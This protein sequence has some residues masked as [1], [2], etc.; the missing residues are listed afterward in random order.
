F[1]VHLHK[2]KKAVDIPLDGD[3]G[4]PALGLTVYPGSKLAI[5]LGYDF[6]FDFGLSRTEDFYV[7]AKNS[8]LTLSFDAGLGPNFHAAAKLAFLRVDVSDAP[9]DPNDPNNLNNPLHPTSLGNGAFSV[10]LVNPL[11]GDHLTLD[12]IAKGL[13]DPGSLVDAS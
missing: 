13:T 2:N 6:Q 10:S 3:I 12:G 9:G 4:I 1:N 8:H 11:G 5:N 7:D